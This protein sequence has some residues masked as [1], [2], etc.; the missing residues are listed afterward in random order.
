MSKS[1]KYTGSSKVLI[2][3]CAAVNELQDSP[4]GGTTY[5]LSLDGNDLVLTPASGEEQRV[6]LPTDKDTTYTMSYTNGVLRLIPSSGRQQSVS[7]LGLPA[8]STSD[9]GKILRVNSSGAWEAQALVNA[10][11]TEY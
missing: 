6:T 11:T 8:V 10:D 3:L 5:T 7:L 1:I 9:S 4:S 2:R